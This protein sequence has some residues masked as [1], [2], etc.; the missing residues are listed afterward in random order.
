MREREREGFAQQQLRARIARC[1]ALRRRVSICDRPLSRLSRLLTRC[2]RVATARRADTESRDLSYLGST[3]C[4][5]Q[6]KSAG[7]SSNGKPPPQIPSSLA[8][9]QLIFS[10]LTRPRSSAGP[11][12]VHELVP[13]AHVL[14][15]SGPSSSLVVRHCAGACCN[16]IAISKARSRACV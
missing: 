13:R 9:L 12:S 6:K 4:I 15:V 14:L 8:P 11:G 16:W 7:E 1:A 3:S 10:P 2:C 5:E